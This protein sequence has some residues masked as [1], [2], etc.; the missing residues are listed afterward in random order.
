MATDLAQQAAE[1]AHQFA[2]WLEQR[3]PGSVLDEVRAFARQRP[4]AFL[5]IAF[6]AGVV[7][8]RLVR[9]LTADPDTTSSDRVG[10]HPGRPVIMPL[11]TP[12]VPGARCSA[13]LPRSTEHRRTAAP[14]AR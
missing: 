9:G 4:G 1:K 8:G 5:A 2:G 11:V 14:P 3:D 12:P 7:T 6:G 13:R 10:H